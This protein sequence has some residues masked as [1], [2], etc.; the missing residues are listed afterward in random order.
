MGKSCDF[1]AAAHFPEA[2]CREALQISIGG[3]GWH[4]PRT[5]V[6]IFEALDLLSDPRTGG[7]CVARCAW[8]PRS[9]ESVLRSAWVD[10]CVL[11]RQGV[12]RV[13]GGQSYRSH[14]YF[15]I[16][17]Q[18]IHCYV[19]RDWELAADFCGGRFCHYGWCGGVA[20]QPQKISHSRRSNEYV[21]QPF[22]ASRW[23]Q[24]V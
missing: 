11:W 22:H 24:A 23:Q 7:F 1:R 5:C 14:P 9:G 8:R 13:R 19:W 4:A 18:G 21:W 2:G 17:R 16:G 3:T 20:A 15:L 10:S 6:G 12:A